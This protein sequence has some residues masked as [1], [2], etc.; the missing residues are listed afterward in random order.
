[1]G[2][3]EAFLSD[4]FESVSEN[5]SLQTHLRWHDVMVAVENDEIDTALRRYHV[6]VSPKVSSRRTTLVDSAA[7]LWRLRIDGV[8][9]LSWSP[10]VD[11]ARQQLTTP[12]I[13]LFDIHAALALA[14]GDRK[15]LDVLRDEWRQDRRRPHR[16]IVVE[17]MNAIAAFA[18]DR[19]DEAAQTLSGVTAGLSV[20]GG[21]RLQQDVVIDTLCDALVRSG[22]PAR[23]IEI[24]RDRQRRRGSRRDA[25]WIE[26][27]TRHDVVVATSD[28]GIESLKEKEER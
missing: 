4:W 5:S 20:L 17:V 18:D 19:F 15:S 3:L 21:S 2:L 27:L 9:D 1:M 13:A 14:V 10:V 16:G 26:D 6:A 12:G 8:A 11:L 23:A 22:E 28:Q 24:L 25:R 7:T